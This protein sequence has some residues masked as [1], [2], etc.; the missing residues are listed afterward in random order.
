[1]GTRLHDI[2][3]A[4][5]PHRTIKTVTP[6][7]P[8]AI[9]VAYVIGMFPTA[10]LVGRRIGLDPTTE[11]SGNPG[12]SNVY[13]LAGSRAGIVVAAGD[14]AKALIP[15][16]LALL[17]WGRPAA[18][19]IWPA[20]VLGHVWPLLRRFRG[21]K[22]VATVSGGVIVLEPLIAAL[23]TMIFVIVVKSTRI[24]ALGSLSIVLAYPLGVALADRPGWELAVGIAMG[25]LVMLRHHGNIDKM[26]RR[27]ERQ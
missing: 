20:V 23:C 3:G 8:V 5:G 6:V 15:T 22:G 13:R 12:A 7:L 21:G 24:A 16:L 25:A 9:V 27:Q 2:A 26:L 18:F 17:V 4:E 11:G 19:A 1:M 14:V 10:L